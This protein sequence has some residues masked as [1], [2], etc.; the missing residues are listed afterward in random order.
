MD[1]RDGLFHY[2][3]TDYRSSTPR[4]RNSDVGAVETGDEV[5]AKG[6]PLHGMGIHG[7]VAK[8]FLCMLVC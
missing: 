4:V 1:M 7:M 8:M 2:R 5:G 6:T 3:K